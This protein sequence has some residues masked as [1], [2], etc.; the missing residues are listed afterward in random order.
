MHQI[1]VS[2]IIIDVVRKDIKNLHL[3]VYPPN[4]R[5]R[6]AAPLNIDDEAVRLF[7][8][9][10]LSWIK[11]H[12]TNFDAQERQSV[13]E[14]ISGESHYYNGKRYLLNVIYRKGVPKVELRRKNL[15]N[16]DM[17]MLTMVSA[18]VRMTVGLRKLKKI[19]LLRSR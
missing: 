17:V 13:R 19:L 15:L 14:Y 11:K 4:G 12:Q 18:F 2:N 5:I 10:K 7:A 8:I 3:A 9:S 6:I 16:L 1:T